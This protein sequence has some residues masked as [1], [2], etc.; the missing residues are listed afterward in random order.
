MKTNTNLAQQY[1]FRILLTEDNVTNQK[2]AL[3]LLKR[4]GYS[5]DVVENG[6]KAIQAFARQ[7]Y[8]VI[9]MDIQMP[10]MDG[11]EATKYIREHW[12]T[13]ENYP[14]IIAVTAHAIPGYREMCLDVG[15]NDYITKPV[16]L[17]ELKTALI[18]CH[19]SIV[20]YQS[21]VDSHQENTTHSGKKATTGKENLI[22]ANNSS[23]RIEIMTALH[24]LVGGYEPIIKDLIQTYLNSSAALISDL[25]A[26]VVDQNP[27]RL[28]HSAHSLKSSSA[29][30]GA[31]V[32]SDLCRQLEQQGR[33]GDMIDAEAKVQRV[34]SES[35]LVTQALNYILNNQDWN[36]Q[37]DKH[38]KEVRTQKSE[39][40]TDNA[41]PP[42]SNR[43]EVGNYEATE[44]ASS[45][46]D[47]SENTEFTAEYEP[48]TELTKKI[49][50]TLFSLIGE[51]EPELFAELI[52]T[53]SNEGVNLM[54]L[55]REAIMKGDANQL[56]QVAH[57]FKSSS[58]NLG[59]SQLANYCQTLEQQ[60]KCYD[61]TNSAA[62]FAQLEKEYQR[63]IRAL[64]TLSTTLEIQEQV[65]TQSLSEQPETE[66]PIQ[67]HDKFQTPKV[68]TDEDTQIAELIQKIQDSLLM[69]VG[70]GDIELMVELI[71]AYSNE[72]VPLRNMLSEAIAKGDVNQLRQTAHSLKSSSANLSATQLVNCCQTLEQQAK[73][74]D[75]SHSAATFAQLETEYQRVKKALDILS[76][77][78]SSQE[79]YW[80]P[81]SKAS[82]SP[83]S[84][85]FSQENKECLISPPLSERD[86]D[87][88]S[89]PAQFVDAEK[90]ALL[91]QNIQDSIMSFLGEDDAEMIKNLGQSYKDSAKILI[92]SLREAVAQTDANALATAA[93][94]L[95]SS[96]SYL[97]AKRLVEFCFSLEKKGK[98]GDMGE[99]SA[100]LAQLEVEYIYV[101]MALDQIIGQ[102]NEMNCTQ[103]P[104]VLTDS[105]SYQ[106]KL[107]I[108]PDKSKTIVS[109][110]D[111]KNILD[112]FGE[113]Q[114]DAKEKVQTETIIPQK[115][116]LSITTEA[117]TTKQNRTILNTKTS[118]DKSLLALPDS[119]QFKILVVDD[120]AYEVLLITTYLREEGYQVLTANSGK[121][122]LD[123][124]ATQLPN[125][126]LSDV[127]M[128]GMNGFELCQN[129]KAR[130]QSVLTQVVLV[131]SLE[132]QKDRIE[133]LQAGADEFLSKPIN[134]EELMA[135]VRSLLRYQHTRYQLEKAH[136]E[137][138]KQM[139]KR[140]ISPKWVD[141]ILE[142]PEKAEILVDQQNRQEAVILFADLR[143]FTAMSEQIQ[144]KEVVA[145]LN[146]FFTMLTD[147][148]YRYDGTIFNMAGDCLLIGFGVP[149]FQED[150]ALRALHA[151]SEMLH[152]FRHLCCS[153][154]EVYHVKVGLGIGIN[155]GEIIVGNVG[156]PTYM[157]YTVIGDTVNVASRLVG[158]ADWGEIIVSE[159]V[160]KAINCEDIWESAEA[161][162]PVTLKGKSQP[163]QVYK[164][165]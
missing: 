18:R 17:E 69:V 2:V 44:I 51:D 125:I 24:E 21:S 147:V 27:T 36:E 52:Q 9:L 127:I 3:N 139:F 16:R 56:S 95:K 10:E 132:G 4:L 75:L 87:A 126:V 49:Q 77:N 74:H 63:V 150:S 57:S 8:D 14:Y 151:A 101:G 146:E 110:D 81:E 82:E 131:T 85:I 98:A 26:A 135:R 163:Q 116:N 103:L 111:R 118:L 104:M 90:V 37:T 153:W 105:S 114:R 89:I 136:K 23:L 68:I 154:Q 112:L 28:E 60:A 115:K 123:I 70:D 155:K 41:I 159:S 76:K 11:L 140:Y 54:N 12:Y 79:K 138:L 50:T 129:I 43:E 32:L 91:V 160:L 157:N 62:S 48:L 35:A 99:I 66:G 144:P 47:E 143:G 124:I 72:A 58:A 53:Y 34:I 84:S 30:L 83:I 25:Q 5:A 38:L 73:N 29:S 121:E 142:N 64:K 19:T 45:E 40:I 133:G 117:N 107:D 120:Q 42:L 31:T 96:S 137:Q 93:H 7:S 161:L 6:A 92:E 149:F 128:P 97:G 148:A 39:L 46:A 94:T 106:K 108:E 164:I 71:Q 152:E 119:S 130:Q 13:S 15:M 109:F 80:N 67:V 22:S 141:E 61:L 113:S 134:R 100:L 162:P 20:S 59:A 156:S 65:L 78:L 88:S 122:A 165:G 158:L 55:L 102:K 1:P 145:L 33:V 86:K